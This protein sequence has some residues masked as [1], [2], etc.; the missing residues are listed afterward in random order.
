MVGLVTTVRKSVIA[1]T[2]TRTVRIIRQK[3]DVTPAVLHTSRD[4]LVK[5]IYFVSGKYVCYIY[6]LNYVLFKTRIPQL[7]WFTCM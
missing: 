2:R 3:V 6:L 4:P 5:V 7:Y 1:T